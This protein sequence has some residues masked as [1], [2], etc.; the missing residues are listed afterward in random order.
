MLGQDDIQAQQNLLVTHRSRLAT[1]LQQQAIHGIGYTPPGI[2]ADIAVA[3]AE[4]QRIKAVLR[5]S[6]I[7]VDDM[8]NDDM[9]SVNGTVKPS[10]L[11]TE[12]HHARYPEVGDD[13]ASGVNFGTN[14]R[15]ERIGDVIGGDNIG[16]DKIID[17]RRGFFWDQARIPL[18]IVIALILVFLVLSLITAGANLLGFKGTLQYMGL[19]PHDP[20]PS[21]TTTPA[22]TAEPLLFSPEQLGENLIIVV[23]F[24]RPDNIPDHDEAYIIQRNIRQNLRERGIAH[25]RVE[26]ADNKQIRAEDRAAVIALAQHYH[27]SM[28]I[29]GSNTGLEVVVN[30]LNLRQP[31]FDAADVSLE[32]T[33]EKGRTQIANPKA[34]AGFITQDVPSIMIF[35]SLF[36]VGQS[37]INDQQHPLA[38]QT[39]SSALDALNG[40][41]PLPQGV[42]DAYFRLGWLY[43]QLGQDF[44]IAKREYDRAIILDPNYALAYNNRGTI[45]SKI[46][47]TDKALA[48]YNQAI[49]LDPKLVRA[50][51]NRGIIYSKIGDTDEA[52]ADYNQAIALDPK[53]ALAYNNRG[54]LFYQLGD[55][56]KALAD[57]NQAIALNPKFARAYNNRG[58]LVEEQL[59][60]TDKA[61]ADYNQAI[62]LD[63]KDAAAYYNRGLIYQQ[64]GERNGAIADFRKAR[65]LSKDQQDVQEARDR[66]KELGADK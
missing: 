51:N 13:K 31:N 2:I 30:Y 23:P 43:Q 35:L 56:D 18:L 34:Y 38:I 3:R 26:V 15:I 53:H 29:W 64:R 32:E 4:I 46:G 28:I 41:D 50:Y 33:G 63:P 11:S 60:D 66:L 55:T 36:A 24:F 22:P 39:I 16:R 45:Y 58:V 61:L 10:E 37:A 59:G 57:Y 47:D 25:V 27:A 7:A 17:N 19:V 62:A 49:A 1:L 40:V 44:I 65:D 20:T 12:L 52:L 9:G 5:A 54:W 42:A 6:N 21:P 8:P 48:D 14:N